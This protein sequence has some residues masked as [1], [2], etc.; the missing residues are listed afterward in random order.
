MN[1]PH[2]PVIH[3]KEKP[4][5]DLAPAS[6]VPAFGA[7]TG[8]DTPVLK[9]AVLDHLLYTCA[10]DVEEASAL[11][12]YTALAHAVRDR[13]VHRWLATERT[14]QELDVKRAYYLSSE[15]L[16]G[17]SLGLCLLNLGLQEASRKLMAERGFDLETILE[18]EGDPGLGNGGLGRLAAC[19]M[20]SLATLALPAVGYG[21]RYEYG[22]FEQQIENGAQVERRDAWL[23]FGNAWEIP[24]H[25]LS[26]TVRFYGRVETHRDEKGRLRVEWLDTHDVLG[27]PYDSFVVGHQNNTVNTLRLWSAKATKDFD[28]HLFNEGDYR[29]AVEQKIDS[30]SISKVLYPTDKTLEGKVLRLKQQYFFVA[31]S[32]ADIVKDY[33]ERHE[34]FHEFPER[35][36]IQLNDTH[37]AIA[38]AELMR[39]L[40]D[41]ELLDWEFAWSITTRTLGYTNH[42]LLPEALEKWPVRMFET[43]LPRHLQII[44][45]INRRF[46]RQVEIRWPGDG[47]RLARLSIIE[48][49]TEKQVRMAHLAT[50][51]SFSVNGVAQLHTELIKSHLMPEFYE[52]FPER[53]NNKTNG[54]TPRRWMLH[55]NPKLSEFISQRIGETWINENLRDLRR[56]RDFAKDPVALEELRSIKQ[57]NKE[58][59]ATLI[60][61]RAGTYVS[62]NS[63]FVA[64]IKR[65]HEYKRQLLAVLQIIALYQKLRNNPHLTFTPRTYIFA[66]KAAA[67]YAMAKLHI[68]LI[69]AI[70]DVINFDPLVKNRIKVSFIPNYSVSLAQLIIPAADVS[71]Q[72]SLAGKEA[73]GTGNMKFAMNGA[74]TLGTLDGANVE[75]REEVGEENFYLFGLRTPEVQ[76]L[77]NSGY[78]PATFI[79]RS[80]MLREVLELIESGFFSPGEPE[81]F[82]DITQN[83]R[84]QD[85]YMVCADFDDYVRAERQ[86]AIDYEDQQT[87]TQKALLN[88]AGSGKFSSDET[89]RQY[90]AEIWRISPVQVN[91]SHL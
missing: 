43:L 91:L 42:T 70:A 89:I 71:V 45:E 9:R 35:V 81:R 28:L 49:G 87:W 79:E 41:E 11:D 63:M 38:V 68:R 48:E 56:L 47:E 24:R 7:R 10:K 6:L 23:Q 59:L 34:T 64:Q 27:L 83:L 26:K 84:F 90:A 82:R 29:R 54:V 36:A 51:G 15:F 52:L 16:V 85:P 37:P 74:L 8:M 4:E 18:Q 60:G 67:G 32:I 1:D 40:L 13:L 62:P 46:L 58:R 5:L 72:I 78:N 88:I 57:Y 14:Y 31:C 86:V 53:F 73:S 19:F 2:V 75:I 65:F 22:I 76:A 3:R 25:D 21:I 69:N 77:R 30:E 33:K 50:I 66:G 80:P 12:F 55:A 17:R 44:Y 39:V 20:D 61:E